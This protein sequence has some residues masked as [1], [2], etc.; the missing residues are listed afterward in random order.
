MKICI[1]FLI[2]AL[3]SAGAIQLSPSDLDGLYFHE[4]DANG[5]VVTRYVG[6][7]GETAPKFVRRSPLAIRTPGATVDKRDTGAHCNK[8]AG[9]PNDFFTAEGGLGMFFGDNG[10]NFKK[11]ISYKF[12]N[13]VAFGCD[14]GKGQQYTGCQLYSDIDAVDSLCGKGGAGWNAHESSKSSYGRTLLS[15]PFC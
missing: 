15:E 6:L 2:A 4:D 5:T 13:A 12:G 8:L 11:A 14:Y 1:A 10:Q 3:T 7:M 9:S